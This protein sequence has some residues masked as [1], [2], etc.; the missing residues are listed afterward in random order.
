MTEQDKDLPSL[1]SALE[2]ALNSVTSSRSRRE[3]VI[4]KMVPHLLG[5]RALMLINAQQF[6]NRKMEGERSRSF[7]QKVAEINNVL[8]RVADIP[9]VAALI[10]AAAPIE[11]S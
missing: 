11:D 7:D 6:A 3:D 8:A 5:L 2:A 4:V 10:G 1:V 9:E